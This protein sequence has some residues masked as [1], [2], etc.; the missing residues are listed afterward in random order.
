MEGMQLSQGPAL[1][2]EALITPLVSV[3][4]PM[5]NS[6]ATI[7]CL[8]ESLINQTLGDFELILDDDGSKPINITIRNDLKSDD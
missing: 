7:E 4:V 1:H 5:Y 6:A 8:L 3:V 2:D